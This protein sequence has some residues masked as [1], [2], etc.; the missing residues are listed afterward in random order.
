MFPGGIDSLEAF[1]NRNLQYTSYAKENNI[2]GK[3][4]VS[5]VVEKDGSLTNVK[6]WSDI[7]GGC[8]TEAMRVVKLMPKWIPGKYYGKPV[9]CVRIIPITFAL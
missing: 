5:F 6:V 7:G 1:V 2:T 3:V 8:G 4:F 9:R